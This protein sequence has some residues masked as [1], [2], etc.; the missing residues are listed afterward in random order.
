MRFCSAFFLVAGL[1][2]VACAD[3][4]GSGADVGTSSDTQASSAP[5]GET[6]SG[7]TTSSGTGTSAAAS[8]V[9]SHPSVTPGATSTATAGSGH[10]SLETSDEHATTR[11]LS[12]VTQPVASSSSPSATTGDAETEPV[13]SADTSTDETS[14]ASTTN[15]PDIELPGELTSMFPLPNA[16]GVCPDPSLR[17]GFVSK[18]TLGSSGK[19][20]VF[21]SGNDTPVA[22]VDLAQSTVTDTVG[23]SQFKL[24]IGAYVDGNSVVFTLPARGLGFGKSYYVTIEDGVVRGS[25]GDFTIADDTTWRFSTAAAAPNDTSTLRVSLGPDADYC[26][27]QGALDEATEGTTISV[28]PGTYYGA[29]YVT[30]KQGITLRGDDRETTIIAGVNNNNLNPSTRGRALFGSENLKD[31]TLSNLTIEN[32]TPQDGSQAEALAL[33]SC[34]RC[35]VR[36]A[37]IR[38]LQDTL[39]WSG[40]VYADNCYIEGNVDYIWGTGAAYF[41]ACEIRTVGRKGY[42][43]QARNGANGHGY[44]F[45]DSK[46]TADPGITGDVLARIDVAEYPNSEVAYIDCEIGPHISAQ[47][48]TITGGGAPGSLR[49]LEYQSRDPT[50]NLLNVSSRASGSRQLTD[51]EASELRDPVEVLGGWDP[52]TAD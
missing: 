12:E 41:N 4:G 23:G 6:N 36:D 19:V 22:T 14:S 51:T 43:V 1:D 20:R 25:D 32:R 13:N 31:F 33:L 34:D 8:S 40:R 17:L 26:S 28:G 7:Q 50:G 27:I 21:E 15:P 24:P 42:N 37:N 2:C 10:N 11:E 29:V 3:S 38:S 45:V 49:F 47:A 18:P 35:I 52:T 5:A 48:W 16:E 39:L 44:V 30:D 9:A 46:L